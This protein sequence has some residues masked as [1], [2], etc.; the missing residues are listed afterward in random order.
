MYIFTHPY[1]TIKTGD[2][3]VYQKASANPHKLYNRHQTNI[4]RGTQIFDRK[5]N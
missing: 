3:E 4:E 2:N 1:N 5:A